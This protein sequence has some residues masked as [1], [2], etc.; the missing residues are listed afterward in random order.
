M[1]QRKSSFAS[2]SL[3]A[4]QRQIFQPSAAPQP[5]STIHN[6]KTCVQLVSGAWWLLYRTRGSRTTSGEARLHLQ[7]EDGHSPDFRVTGGESLLLAFANFIKYK[8]QNG[9]STLY[10]KTKI[11]AC[12]SVCSC[13]W[14]FFKSSQLQ[15]PV[16]GITFVGDFRIGF[17][18][19]T[20]TSLPVHELIITIS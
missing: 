7:T 14:Y 18:K 4:S 10:F 3:K 8:Y 16:F 19:V 20:K 13:T 15:R 9:V 1:E 11:C 17:R 2:G 12:V 5:A 6:P